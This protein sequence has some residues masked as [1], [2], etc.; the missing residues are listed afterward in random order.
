MTPE[1]P[2]DDTDFLRRADALFERALDLEVDQRAAFLDGACAGDPQLRDRVESLLRA[3]EHTQE[4]F[5]PGRAQEHGLFQIEQELDEEPLER[6]DRYELLEEVGRGGMGVVYRA[7][8]A[9]GAFEQTVAV[10]V[11]RSSA[12]PSTVARFSRERQILATLDHP[13]IAR[14]LDGGVTIE[15]RPYL[16]VEF[17]EGRRL[18]EVYR[19]EPFDLEARL[20][21]LIRLCE[22]VESAH[23]RLIVHRDIKP[24]NVIVRPDGVPK[25]LDFGIAKLIRDEGNVELTRAQQRVMTLQ[26]ASPEQ[27]RGVPV[28]VASDVYQLGLVAYEVL[29]GVRPYE[30][31]STPPATAERLITEEEPP[32]PST[33]AGSRERRRRLEG[34]LDRVV[35]K[36]LR[37]DV[38]QRYE[39][40]AQLREDLQAYLEGRP[41][42]ARPPSWSDRTTKFVRRNA[43]AV[44][45]AATLLVVLVTATVGFTWRL[46]AERDR[47]R[48]E[49]ER[50][51]E[52]ESIARGA[53][54]EAERSLDFFVELMSSKTTPEFAE[55]R[56]ISVDRLLDLGLEDVDA[57]LAEH[58]RAK[59]RTLW[60]LGQI[61]E[62]WG[63]LEQAQAIQTEAVAYIEDQL[64]QGFEASELETTL[65]QLLLD[66]GDIEAA[67]GRGQ[68]AIELQERGVA[69][70]H[71]WFPPDS[72]VRGWAHQRLAINHVNLGDE[73]AALENA[74]MAVTALEA[75]YPAG[76][77]AVVPARRIVGDALVSLGRYGEAQD[78]LE[79][80]IAE[81]ETSM[82]GSFPLAAA[83]NGL[84]NAASGLGDHE[85]A[86]RAYRIATGIV[87]RFLP[88]GHL[89]LA[90][91][92]W[93]LGDALREL[94]RLDEALAT[95]N[96]GVEQARLGSHEYYG[97]RLKLARAVTYARLGRVAD[98]LEGTR[99]LE[100]LRGYVDDASSLAA[101]EYDAALALEALGRWEQAGELYQRSVELAEGERGPD[102]AVLAKPLLGLARL[103][104][105]DAD[106]STASTHSRRALA[107]LD[108]VAPL[109]S[110]ARLQALEAWVA[111]LRGV[112]DDV[113][114]AEGARFRTQRLPGRSD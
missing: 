10:K 60:T 113:A 64:D 81:L 32:P 108:A 59:A 53:L 114:A 54:D 26:Y 65:G 57:S 107:L 66:L 79:A 68:A 6:I 69:L 76:H 31:H 74:R 38:E 90:T 102:H 78:H 17:V 1:T 70:V 22:A 27:V 4:R 67:R 56:M 101:V 52:Q 84:G 41:V 2:R 100:W 9:D 99:S 83:A 111:A 21:L 95:Q 45:V 29:C 106:W 42:R 33:H 37:K 40:V 91:S 23:R 44:L 35:M 34:D 43:A 82:P 71:K 20:R 28:T 16:V 73:E 47:T 103:A 39:T 14:L 88:D 72:S 86:V 13:N 51:N 105:R 97:E 55:D 46:I 92:A 62:S 5:S 25:L 77:Q 18:D 24:G 109:D 63:D 7:R 15:G 19:D 94:G 12:E 93:A 36:A 11:L 61:A 112:G 49:A 3:T 8:R 58:P 85:A 80:L 50:A 48:A 89:I 30:L 98:A 87:T 104:A 75:N 96:R 110:Q